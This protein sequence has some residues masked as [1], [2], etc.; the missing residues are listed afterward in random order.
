MTDDSEPRQDGSQAPAFELRPA[1]PDDALC[2]AV[3]AQQVYLDTYATQGI[4]PAIAR[5]VHAQFS[6]A[7]FDALMQRDDVQLEVAERLGH[8]IGFAQTH[9]GACHALAPAGP[10]AELVRLYVQEPF[11]AQG[12]GTALLHSAEKQAAARGHVLLWLTPWIH[13]HRTLAYYARRGY[14]DL[15]ATDHIIEGERHGNRVFAKQI[16]A[17]PSSGLTPRAAP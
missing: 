13:N 17:A 6:Q 16:V 11:T 10:S 4:R 5:D 9:D 1:R 15:G 2:L 14:A 8:L 7:A 12:V 3:L